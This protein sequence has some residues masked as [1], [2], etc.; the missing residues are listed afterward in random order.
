MD[1]WVDRRSDSRTLEGRYAGP[2]KTSLSAYHPTVRA[3]ISILHLIK[4][5]INE[6][7]AYLLFE[8]DGILVF[9]ALHMLLASVIT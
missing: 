6:S 8:Q 4:S 9:S 7:A 1:V 3:T 2:E 5:Q